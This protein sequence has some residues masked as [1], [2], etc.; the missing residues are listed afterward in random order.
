LH[1]PYKIF[2]VLCIVY[3]GRG[4]I[5]MPLFMDRGYESDGTRKLGM[6]LNYAPIVPPKSIS[7]PLRIM[8][9]KYIRRGIR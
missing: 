1:K 6:G 4:G 5:K 8:I 7:P 2:P 3:K 9:G